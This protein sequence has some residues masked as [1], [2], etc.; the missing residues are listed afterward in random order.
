MYGEDADMYRP[1]R[2]V[3]ASADQRKRMDRTVNLVFAR[4]RFECL[5]KS[6][7]LM[8]LN[9][10]IFELVKKYDISLANSLKP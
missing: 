7:A 5:G 6:V 2:W 9:K 3:Q 8:E 1:D 4:G 10:L